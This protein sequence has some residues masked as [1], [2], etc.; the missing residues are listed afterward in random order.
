MILFALLLVKKK[1]KKKTLIIGTIIGV[2]FVI[3]YFIL[4][5]TNIDSYL[6][7]NIAVYSNE[8]I[9]LISETVFYS[10]LLGIFLSELYLTVFDNYNEVDLNINS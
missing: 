1:G 10:E 4:K 8:Y 9:E 7:T 6:Y 2:V 3:V 5:F